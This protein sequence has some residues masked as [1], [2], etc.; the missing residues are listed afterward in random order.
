M[1]NSQVLQILNKYACHTIDCSMTKNTHQHTDRRN[2]HT[3]KQGD[4]YI[5]TEVC[6]CGLNDIRD[7]LAL[8]PSVS[9]RRPNTKIL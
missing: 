4:Y 1:D 8:K 9:E 6:D 3:E 2:L 5:T 7:K